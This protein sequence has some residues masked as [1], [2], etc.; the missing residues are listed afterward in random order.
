LIRQFAKMGLAFSDSRSAVFLVRVPAAAL[1]HLRLADLQ[2]VV[3]LDAQTALARVAGDESGL[4]WL[5]FQNLQHHGTNRTA[6]TLEPHG[7]LSAAGFSS[8]PDPTSTL[9][10]CPG[11]DVFA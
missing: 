8:G 5:A 2:A 7:R 10:P 4:V 3:G 6:L 9:L 1:Q 11:I